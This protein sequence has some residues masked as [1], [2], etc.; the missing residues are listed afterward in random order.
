M[1]FYDCAMD[2]AV[3]PHFDNH[4]SP[5]N[6]GSL[7]PEW[8]GQ[9]FFR[10]YPKSGFVGDIFTVN[11]KAY[12]VL[13]VKPRRYR[14]RFL[15]ASIA[16]C[17][18]LSLRF[19]PNSD[20]GTG[21]T[22]VGVF[23]G[24]QG[25]WNFAA[26]AKSG[27]ISRTAGTLAKTSDGKPAMLQIA[28][29]GGLLKNAIYRDAIQ[30]W[31][32]KRREVIIDFS[33]PALKGKTLYLVNSMLQLD[34]K[35]PTFAG[36]KG[37]DPN[38]AIPLI[39]ICVDVPMNVGE[40]D[41]SD[42]LPK[43]AGKTLRNIPSKSGNI[44]ATPQFVLNS[45]NALNTTGPYSAETQWV[46]NGLEFDAKTPLHTVTEGQPEQWTIINNGGGWTHPLHI[47]QEEHQVIARAG[48]T[49]PHPED[50]P[51]AVGKEDVVALD[52]GETVTIYRN[53]RTFAGKFVA[54]CHNLA[55]EDHN[56]MFGWTIR[57]KP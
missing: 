25:Q 44:A 35:K 15:G 3:T 34:G 14:F 18:E 10:H 28:S 54:H 11:G 49:N 50:G 45:N 48:S 19:A 33:D 36:V 31:P 26:K 9:S 2:D 23:P 52:P 56:M 6:C 39:K 32:A 13:H 29:D 51:P 4:Q 1:A 8:W 17:Y 55:H 37:F 30:I 24:L 42:T 16:R 22:G 57:P 5:V 20:V 38:Y 41:N 12:P 47:H 53:F 21:V 43:I 27:V 40:V 7:H 46:I